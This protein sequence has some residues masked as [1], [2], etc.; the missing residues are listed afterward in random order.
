MQGFEFRVQG[1]VLNWNRLGNNSTQSQLTERPKPFQQLRTT[2]LPRELQLKGDVFSPQ[3]LL[4]CLGS[5]AA[6]HLH[7]GIDTGSTLPPL[8]RGRK[9]SVTSVSTKRQRP[10]VW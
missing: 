8:L 7:P 9:V 2:P 5:G 3:K 1:L 10:L 6:T 4:V